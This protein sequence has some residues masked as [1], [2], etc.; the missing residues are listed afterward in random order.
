[1]I[2]HLKRPGDNNSSN[3]PFGE[4]ALKHYAAALMTIG[5]VQVLLGACYFLV[6]GR[7]ALAAVV[8]GICT[9]GLPI[10]IGMILVGIRKIKKQRSAKGRPGR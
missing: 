3:H 5:L 6:P 8:M 10:G 7:C 4:N 9:G 2:G 1:M